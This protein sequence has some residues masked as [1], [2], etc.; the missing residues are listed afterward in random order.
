M[1]QFGELLESIVATIK[2]WEDLAGHLLNSIHI[3]P[4]RLIRWCL[5][6]SHLCKCNQTQRNT[7]VLLR[8]RSQRARRY[9]ESSRPPDVIFETCSNTNF[10]PHHIVWCRMV[11]K[12]QKESANEIIWTVNQ[13]RRELHNQS[14]ACVNLC[15]NVQLTPM[16]QWNTVRTKMKHSEF[17][18]HGYLNIFPTIPNYPKFTLRNPANKSLTW[19]MMFSSKG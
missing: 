11:L 6:R 14:I 4:S 10:R 17:T 5:H 8:R 2:C 3:G 12:K 7:F 18:L 16:F 15:S 13:Q 1:Y 19:N 9:Q